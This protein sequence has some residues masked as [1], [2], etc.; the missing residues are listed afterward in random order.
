MNQEYGGETQMQKH[1]WIAIALIAI[2]LLAA[3][4]GKKDAGPSAAVPAAAEA[5]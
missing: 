5:A 1:A 4:G 2:L 3:C